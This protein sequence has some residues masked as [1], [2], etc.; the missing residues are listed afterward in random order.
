M[1]AGSWQK[2]ILCQ[3]RPIDN[4]TTEKIFVR[5]LDGATC[6]VPVE[7]LKISGN[8]YKILES[9]DFADFEEFPDHIYEFWPGDIVELG[10]HEFMDRTTGKVASRLVEAGRWPDRK[11]REFKFRATLG[12]LRPDLETARHYSVEIQRLKD[13][14]SKGEFSYQLVLDYVRIFDAISELSK[15]G[16]I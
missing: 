12:L 13:E 1:W 5:L 14:I 8:H 9:S 4:L 11:L 10:D 2:S 6:W 15:E 3:P 16:R 7:A